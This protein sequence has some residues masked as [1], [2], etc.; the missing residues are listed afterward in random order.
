MVGKVHPPTWRC[1]SC[2]HEWESWEIPKHCRK[3]Q[4][5]CV[6]HVYIAGKIY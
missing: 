6:Y 3:C 2:N 4:S 5:K 1:K